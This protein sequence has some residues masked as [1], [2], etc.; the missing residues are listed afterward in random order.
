MKKL[1]EKV[2]DLINEWTCPTRAPRDE[3]GEIQDYLS[4]TE[5]SAKEIAKEVKEVA[6]DFLCKMT[7]GNKYIMVWSEH[8]KDFVL[9]S[10]LFDHFINERYH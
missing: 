8:H 2:D 3:D 1:E 10:D 7:G 6:I 9:R 4:F 5:L